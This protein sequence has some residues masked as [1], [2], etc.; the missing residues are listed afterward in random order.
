MINP[1]LLPLIALFWLITVPPLIAIASLFGRR[2]RYR[3]VLRLT[4]PFCRS[5]AWGLGVRLR[6]LG[7]RDPEALVFVGNHVSWLD[8]LTAG[9]G[10]GGVFVSRHDVADWPLIGIFARLAGTVFI[11]RASLRS[12]IESSREITARTAENIPVVFFPEGETNDGS[13]VAPFHAFLFAAIAERR[14]RV[15]PFTLRYTTVGGAPVTPEN[16]DLVYWYHPDHSFTSHALALLRHRPVT[17]ELHFRNAET[18][19]VDLDRKGLNAFVT[20][21]HHHVSRDIP[22]WE[23]TSDT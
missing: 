15:Q 18:P 21:L 9:W 8:I 19:P 5:I 4:S 1:F 2:S 12:A 7:E 17:A 20:T 14:V 11:D 3:M 22:V 13:E 23:V 6:I 10:V 16:R